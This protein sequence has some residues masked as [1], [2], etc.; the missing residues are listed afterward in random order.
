MS[1]IRTAVWGV[2]GCAITLLALAACMLSALVAPALAVVAARTYQEAQMVCDPTPGRATPSPPGAGTATPARSPVPTHQSP[3][4]PA[5]TSAPP[6][7]C[8]APAAGTIAA[9][10][11]SMAQMLSG[12]PDVFYRTMPP[13]VLAYWQQLCPGCTSWQN[14]NLQCG[15]YAVGVYAWAGVPVPAVPNAAK[16]FWPTYAQNAFPGWIEVP[17]GTGLP[18]PGD[19]M[20]FDT[21]HWP[22]SP[23]HIA[24]VIAVTP[25]AGGHNGAVTFG[26][27]NGPAP[28]LRWALLPTNSLVVPW[29]GYSMLGYIRTLHPPHVG[30]GHP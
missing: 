19:L 23:G 17:D 14:G 12:D 16:D 18:Q 29:N 27:A 9:A 25:P 2:A 5:P 21:P 11:F 22:T 24:V 1:G 6:E 15:M 10:A 20:V 4:S 7:M 28:I 30:A 8:I 26:E 3:A 13:A